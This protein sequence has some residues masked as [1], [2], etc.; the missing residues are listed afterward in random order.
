LPPVARIAVM[1]DI[2]CA[3]SAETSPFPF[4]PFLYAGRAVTAPKVGVELTGVEDEPGA[5]GVDEVGNDFSRGVEGNPVVVAEVGAEPGDSSSTSIASSVV[6]GAD[7][8]SVLLVPFS[9]ALASL[10]SRIR[11]I[12]ASRAI[13][14]IRD[15]LKPSST[16]LL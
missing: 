7:G 8:K 5:T 16:S 3:V 11:V 9:L 14:S 2:L 15:A 12:S 4:L 6:A 13:R 1:F 10:T